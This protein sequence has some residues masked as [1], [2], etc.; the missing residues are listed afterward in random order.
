MLLASPPDRLD[1]LNNSYSSPD[2][3]FIGSHHYS[4]AYDSSPM[5]M[6][7]SSYRTAG[8]ECIVMLNDPNDQYELDTQMQ[9]ATSGLPPIHSIHQHQSKMSGGYVCSTTIPSLNQSIRRTPPPPYQDAP[10]IIVKS[11]S[12]VNAPTKYNR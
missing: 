4:D 7:S 11:E 10:T 3:D 8:D 9:Q 2:Q 5:M 12:K 6:S 1:S